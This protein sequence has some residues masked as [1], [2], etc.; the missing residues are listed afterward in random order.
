MESKSKCLLTLVVVM[1]GSIPFDTAGPFKPSGIR[2]GTPAVTTRGMNEPE[3]N[4]IA[5]LLHEALTNRADKAKLHAIRA[6]VV[7]LNQRFPLP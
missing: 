3:M 4:Q 5:A 6:R 2:L 7:E 1:M